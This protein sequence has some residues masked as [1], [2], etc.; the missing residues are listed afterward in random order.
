MVL[1]MKYE[2][3]LKDLLFENIQLIEMLKFLQQLEPSAYFSAGIIRNL[4]WSILHG[5]EID[6]SDADIDVIYHDSN[7]R[8]RQKEITLLTR[9]S[10][11][12]PSYRWD[13][14]NQAMVHTWYLTAEGKKI[15]ALKSLEQ[16][17]SLW[18]ETATAVAVR[19]V[20]NELEVI[21]PFGLNDLFELK[22]RWNTALVPREVFE[23]RM[24]KKGFLKRW[25]RLIV[26][27]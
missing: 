4:V 18:P 19:W 10:T 25:N 22:L 12:Y 23:Q 21:A 3:E 20:N 8:N 24:I 14:T 7:E 1:L 2:C 13:V 16:A 26:V 27:S 11:E 6:F 15:G 17:I 5:Q 9:L